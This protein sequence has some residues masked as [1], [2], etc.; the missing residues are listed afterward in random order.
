[1]FWN[2]SVVP[3]PVLTV[4]SW[5]AYRFLRRQVRWPGIPISLSIF[6]TLFWKVKGFGVINKAEIDIFLALSCF[7]DDPTDFGNLISG[8]SAFSKFNLSIWKF[9]VHVL[10]KPGL[11]NFE[12]Y[13]AGVWN[14][15]TWAAVWVFFGIA[16]LWDWNESWPF[17]V[18]L[19]CTPWPSRA[20]VLFCPPWTPQ[21][22]RQGWQWL[23]ASE[24]QCPLRRKSQG[25]DFWP[26]LFF[27]GN[28]ENSPESCVYPWTKACA[29]HWWSCLWGETGVSHMT[30]EIRT[31]ARNLKKG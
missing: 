20:S 26:T 3:H 2:P 10:L 9:T 5:P 7:F 8:S 27:P 30:L 24:R 18:F 31:M 6:H 23:L 29:N 25:T 19:T 17:P 12:R 28:S 22:H 1:M 15:C 13:F 16:F 4:A 11:E 21:V 14:E